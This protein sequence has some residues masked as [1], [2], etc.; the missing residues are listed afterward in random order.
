MSPPEHTPFSSRAYSQRVL[1]HLRAPSRVG[2]LESA[3]A[4]GTAGSHL[5]GDLVRLQLRVK[6]GVIADARFQAFGCPATIATASE[7]VSRLPGL[8]LLEAARLGHESI[9]DHLTLPDHKRGCS[10]VAA[11]ALHNALEDWVRSAAPVSRP[12]VE[13]QATVL[14]A[15]SGGVD[16]SAAAL[17]LKEAGLQPAGVTFR[18]WSDPTCSIGSGCCSPETILRA[19]RVAHRL[20]M[21]HVTVDLRG[22][23]RRTVV[24]HF[25]KEYAGAR[26]P[27]PCV[28]CNSMLRF[29]ALVELADR[30]GIDKVATGHYARLLRSPPRLHRALDPAKDQAYVLAGVAPELLER[31]VFPLGHLEKPRVRELARKAGLEVHDAEESQEICFIPDDD[32]RRFLAERLGNA[33]GPIIDR[34][35]RRLGTH[36]GAYRFTIGQR[37][38]LGLAA[39]R[40]LYVSDIRADGAIVVGP[41]EDLLVDQVELRD[42]VR[43]STPKNDEGLTVQLRSSGLVVPVSLKEEGAG[44]TLRLKAEA[45]GVARGQAGVVF[46]GDQVVLAGTIHRTARV[47]AQESTRGH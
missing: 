5:C 22:E 8:D 39:P 20:D 28:T 31:V 47:A 37:K 6:A 32:Y 7:I 24:E 12:G 1:A 3:D 29:S 40:P 17:L 9:A 18:L 23:F 30:L 34:E 26:T 45:A 4:E 33:P 36:D 11:D 42:V 21:P 13:R 41:R 19:R 35:G 15:M 25:V 27:N 44:V 14:V 43:H 16:S 10:E 46:E 38:G 2:R